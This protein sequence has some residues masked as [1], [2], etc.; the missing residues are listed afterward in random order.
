MIFISYN[1]NDKELVQPIANNLATVFG[2]DS[3]FFDDWSIKPGDGIIDKMN[4]GLES[5][6]Y[7]FFFVSK[8]SLQSRMVDLEWQNALLKSTKNQLRLIPVKI[9]DCLMPEILL[10]TLYIDLFGNGFETAVRQII[11][12]VN[13]PI[14]LESEKNQTYENVRAVIYL[15]DGKVCIEIRAMSYM[16]PQ[17]KFNLLITNNEDEFS[18]WEKGSPAVYGGFQKDFGKLNNGRSFNVLSFERQR[19]LSPGFPYILELTPKSGMKL[20]I[21]EVGH[22]KKHNY[23]KY[24]PREYA[25]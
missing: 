9:D 23:F 12:V 13:G 8:S 14:K 17:A 6:K 21:I 24:I 22:A 5:A 2:N 10:Q 16:E 18:W 15:E 11:D 1:H 3:I 20:E 19:P 4:K 7:F 25:R